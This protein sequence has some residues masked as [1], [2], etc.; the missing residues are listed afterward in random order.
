M[1][2]LSEEDDNEVLVESS[3]AHD[4]WEIPRAL[5]LEEVESPPTD[6]AWMY[7]VIE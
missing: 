5:V 1:W 6:D 7:E 3:T 4:A 2:I